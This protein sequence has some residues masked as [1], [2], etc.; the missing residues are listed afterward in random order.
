LCYFSFLHFLFSL[1]S[2]LF[3][4]SSVSPHPPFSP[5]LTA[6][7]LF[8]PWPLPMQPTRWGTASFHKLVVALPVKKSPPPPPRSE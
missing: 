8:Q 1:Y 3:A 2:T 4:S 6:I 7:A 5:L